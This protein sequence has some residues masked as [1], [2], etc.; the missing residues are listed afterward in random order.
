[1]FDEI[2]AFERSRLIPSCNTSGTAYAAYCVKLVSL[3]CVVDKSAFSCFRV[4]HPKTL[5]LELRQ[6]RQWWLQKQHSQLA[7]VYSPGKSERTNPSK[8]ATN[9]EG[10]EQH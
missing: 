3:V 9:N 5:N 2:G 1:M 6:Y 4:N 8:T 7:A 10:N